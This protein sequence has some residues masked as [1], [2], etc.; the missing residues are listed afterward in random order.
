MKFR[1]VTHLMFHNP[2]GEYLR[3]S[4]R[5]VFLLFLKIYFLALDSRRMC[6]IIL[7]NFLFLQVFILFYSGFIRFYPYFLRFYSILFEVLIFFFL[8][9]LSRAYLACPESSANNPLPVGLIWLAR[10]AP[11]KILFSARIERLF[12]S[13]LSTSKKSQRTGHSPIGNRI[14]SD[15]VVGDGGG[16]PDI[17]VAIFLLDGAS[18][19]FF[20]KALKAT[21]FSVAVE[22]SPGWGL[23]RSRVFP[24][25]SHANFF[26]L[27]KLS[28]MAAGG[29]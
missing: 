7:L 12:L 11:P 25:T 9:F 1:M 28:S 19:F 3:P 15:R 8:Y 10:K 22:T 2:T 27:A 21:E 20:L 17:R 5:W 29:R 13:N 14:L 18:R 6:L 24:E 23:P 26:E 16:C 4:V